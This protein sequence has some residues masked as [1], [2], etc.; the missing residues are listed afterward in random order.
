MKK[1]NSILE[2]IFLILIGAVIFFLAHPNFIFKNG[3]GFLGFVTFTPVFL[4]IKNVTRKNAFLYGGIYGSITYCLFLFWLKSFHPVVLI[5]ILIYCFLLYGV[6][7][8]VLK[9][10][11]DYLFKIN[12]YLIPEILA[13]CA[14]EYLRTLGFFG[15]SYGVIAYTQWKFLPLI[16]ITNITGIFGLNLLVIMPGFL[17]GELIFNFRLFTELRRNNGWG[18]ILPHESKKSLAVIF[19]VWAALFVFAIIYGIVDI[20]KYDKFCESNPNKINIALIQNNEDPWE[21]GIEAHKKNVNQLIELSARAQLEND[22]DLIVWPETSVAP[23]ILYHFYKMESTSRFMLVSQI[24][25]FIKSSNTDFVIGNVNKVTDE[26]QN[27]IDYNSVL[28]FDSEK[29]V[30]PPEPEIYSKQHLVPLSEYF[31]PEKFFP[32]LSEILKNGSPSFWGKGSENVVFNSNGF[33]FATP[34]CFEDTFGNDCRKM[35]LNKAHAFVN[36]SN[37]SWSNSIAC[38]KQHLSMA[39]FRSVENRVPTVRCSTSGQTAFVSS[40]GK[41]ENELEPFTTD[42]LFCE[43]PVIENLSMTFYT[44]F[45]DLFA[46]AITIC[47]FAMLIIRRIHIII[48]HTIINKRYR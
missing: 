30:I 11:D 28:F 16:Q 9:I 47:F 21:N 44:R 5:F 43:V 45:G 19:S 6:L 37:D 20:K 29:N 23:S 4:L 34:I 12:N 18:V 26:N 27:E 33:Y 14:F 1:N 7:F 31:P 41:V 13:V 2:N 48:I 38:Q 10:I 40:I 22:V 17:L 39:V 36:L 35:I 25:D 42:Y 15:F 24:L 46:I 32:K 8:G 3:L